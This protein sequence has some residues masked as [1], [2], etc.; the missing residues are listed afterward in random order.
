MSYITIQKRFYY[1]R[2]L[3]KIDRA[4]NEDLLQVYYVVVRF[5]SHNEDIPPEQRCLA[6]GCPSAYW[7]AAVGCSSH[8]CCVSDP[9]CVLQDSERSLIL[10]V[11]P[12]DYVK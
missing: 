5:I 6:L 4:K 7:I 10:V 3:G 11:I 12:I 8:I 9:D 1:R 2:C